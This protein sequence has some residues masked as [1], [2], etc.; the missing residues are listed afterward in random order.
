MLELGQHTVNRCQTDIHVFGKQD[1]VH[2]FR[3]EVANGTVLENFEDLEPR[4]SRFQT[5]GFQLGRISR[6]VV[7][8]ISCIC[9][10]I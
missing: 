6:H 9:F 8:R 10:I 7:D 5:A 1:L 2:V 4:Q 3:T